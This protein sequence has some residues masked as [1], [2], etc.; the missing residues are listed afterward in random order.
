MYSFRYLQALYPTK[1]LAMA[2][3]LYTSDNCSISLWYI[4]V[5]RGVEKLFIQSLPKDQKAYTSNFCIRAEN[6]Y[7]DIS[8]FIFNQ[9]VCS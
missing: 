6:L 5:F 9:K 1:R 3:G 7:N 4:I 2:S 8:V